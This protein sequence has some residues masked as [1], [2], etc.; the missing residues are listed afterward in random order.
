M[1]SSEA[2]GGLIRLEN[3]A[4]T[5]ALFGT[6]QC[7]L[8][9]KLTSRPAVSLLYFVGISSCCKLGMPSELKIIE[10]KA[11]TYYRKLA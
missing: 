1:T 2:N 3:Y 7:N 11:E 10:R 4:N 6:K 8:M 5:I 9:E